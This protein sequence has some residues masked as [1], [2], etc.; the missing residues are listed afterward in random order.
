MK[1]K[2]VIRDLQD[3]ED[4]TRVILQKLHDLTAEDYDASEV[5]LELESIARE[6]HYLWRELKD[7]EV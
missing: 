5:S 4:T 7:G 6:V 2:Q 3:L 1:K